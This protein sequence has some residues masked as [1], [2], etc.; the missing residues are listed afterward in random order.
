[1]NLAFYTPLFCIF[2]QMYFVVTAASNVF[3]INPGRNG[4]N[5]SIIELSFCINKASQAIPKENMIR[6]PTKKI[7]IEL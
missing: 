3:K 6:C 5:P 4:I 7:M 2:V 1:M